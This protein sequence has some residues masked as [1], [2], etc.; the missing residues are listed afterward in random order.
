MEAAVCLFIGEL[1]IRLEVV[2]LLGAFCP[3][4]VKLPVPGLAAAPG[5]PEND[6]RKE[7]GLLGE[8]WCMEGVT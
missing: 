1:L 2:L 6:G 5:E 8:Y 7:A 4:T 3:G